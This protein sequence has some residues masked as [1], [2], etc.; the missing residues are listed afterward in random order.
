MPGIALREDGLRVYRAKGAKYLFPVK[1][2]GAAFRHRLSR[3][4]LQH[5]REAHTR[6]HAQIDPQ[7]WKLAW[8]VDSRGV[9]DGVHALRYLARYVSKTAL[10]ES[11]LHGYDEH[12]N[13]RLRCQNSTTG[14]WSVITLSVDEF[15]RR[16][17]QHVLPKGHVRVRHHGFWSAAAKAKLARVRH[18]LGLATPSAPQQQPAKTQPKCPC[19]GKEMHL[20]GRLD[21]LPRWR[22]LMHLRFAW[23]AKAAARGPP[24]ASQ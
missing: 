1:A 23:R 20:S 15:I 7:V 8:V 19:C 9:G 21:P 11:R 3:L 16:W 18:L 2:L 4:I 17:S 22:D 10:S 24:A 6:H 5:D 12:G 13:I 14:Q